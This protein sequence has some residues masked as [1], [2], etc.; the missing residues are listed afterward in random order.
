MELLHVHNGEWWNRQNWT[1][2]TEATREF[3]MAS[4]VAQTH[5]L[6]T[7]VHDGALHGGTPT[8][9]WMVEHVQ[10]CSKAMSGPFLVPYF[11]VH[12]WLPRYS[13]LTIGTQYRPW[14]SQ[15]TSKRSKFSWNCI[16]TSDLYKSYFT[17]VGLHP[18]SLDVAFTV[19][20]N[21]NSNSQ[22]SRGITTVCLVYRAF[23]STLDARR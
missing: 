6:D 22:G 12:R 5:A 19:P 16:D 4:L 10:S 17:S 2:F 21:Q 8:Q 11:S 7:S 20:S 15:G 23:R 18:C 13:H 1:Q 14:V 9:W 3:C